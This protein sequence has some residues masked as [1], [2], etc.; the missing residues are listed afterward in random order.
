MKK[1]ANVIIFFIGAKRHGKTSDSIK[2]IFP[3]YK[4]ILIFD[5]A[6][7]EEKFFKYRVLENCKETFENEIVRCDI[8]S[9]KEVDEFYNFYVE[10]KKETGKNFNGLLFFDDAK[11]VF[12]GNN[13]SLPFERFLKRTAQLNIDILISIHSFQEIP[14]SLFSFC[15]KII[16]KR[17]LGL[18]TKAITELSKEEQKKLIKI[19]RFVNFKANQNKY[20][21]YVYNRLK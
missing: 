15:D 12:R 16:I 21:S 3:A 18:Y 19:I 6:L 4:K 10:R 11:A 9:D 7:S 5:P 13:K 8:L 1:R 17:D 2:Y 20:F 14:P